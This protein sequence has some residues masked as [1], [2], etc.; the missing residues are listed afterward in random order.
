MSILAP[1]SDSAF[2]EALLAIAIGFVFL[3]NGPGLA[4][5]LVAMTSTDPG[6]AP[7]YARGFRAV[8]GFTLLYGVLG[9]VLALFRTLRP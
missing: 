7:V 8:G 6:K 4:R 3:L 2:V 1:L 9:L 5:E